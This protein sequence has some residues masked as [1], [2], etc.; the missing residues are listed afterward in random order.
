MN[1]YADYISPAYTTSGPIGRRRSSS[2]GGCRARIRVSSSPT[3][4]S[5]A[6]STAW[7]GFPKLRLRYKTCSSWRQAM[8]KQARDCNRSRQFCRRSGRTIRTTAAGCRFRLKHCAGALPAICWAESVG[9][10]EAMIGRACG[11]AEALARAIEAVSEAAGPLGSHR[12][13]YGVQASARVAELMALLK[14]A[15][16]QVRDLTRRTEK[17][18]G[19][20]RAIHRTRRGAIAI[21]RVRASAIVDAPQGRR[22]GRGRPG[23]PRCRRGSCRLV[24]RSAGRGAIRPLVLLG[25]LRC[26]TAILRAPCGCSGWPTVLIRLPWRRGAPLSGCFRLATCRARR[27]FSRFCR[28]ERSRQSVRFQ[29]DDGLHARTVQ[30]RRVD[31]AARRSKCR[32]ERGTLGYVVSGALPF[33]V[34][35]Y[36]VRTQALLDSLPPVGIRP[37][38]FT[39]PGFP[40]DRPHLLA[41]GQDVPPESVRQCNLSSHALAGASRS[42]CRARDGGGCSGGT[43]S[44]TRDRDG[45]G[46]L[47]QSECLAGAHG[48]SLRWRDVRL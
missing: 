33:Q 3:C 1:P 11:D 40:W 14:E 21:G 19:R 46:R 28:E 18:F 45:P 4:R 29:P 12:Q 9:S 8:P 44:R 35:G 42:K 39:Q 34:A 15:N 6:L 48:S 38:C 37:I 32:V 10:L 2:G 31:S 5:L 43:V 20:D 41:P 23:R 26:A 30:E 27:P 25:D 47:E 22:I 16:A 36:S 17:L 7:D 24:S 13:L